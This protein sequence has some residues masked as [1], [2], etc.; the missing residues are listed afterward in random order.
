MSETDSLQSYLKTC[1][2]SNCG[3]TVN[4]KT[5]N[6]KGRDHRSI[7][8]WKKR[9]SQ[10][11]L[12]NLRRNN[13]LRVVLEQIN[14][15][16][17]AI[18]AYNVQYLGSSVLCAIIAAIA[19]VLDMSEENTYAIN[20]FYILPTIYLASLYN[21]VKYTGKQLEIGAYK[22]MLEQQTNLFLDEDVLCWESKIACGK[23]FV[24]LGGGVQIFFY[25]P[26]FVFLMHGFFKLSINGF[27]VFMMIFIIL[28]VLVLIIMAIDLC[29]VKEKTLEKMGYRLAN[30]T[31]EKIIEESNHV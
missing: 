10:S 1:C 23:K 21:L 19:T 22:M 5:Y 13:K 12:S 15:C 20:L 27:W 26:F 8:L 28:E 6:F 11:S 7:I 17:N 2:P 14:L 4:R 3:Q 31:L 30:G 16:S 18:T 24:I 25:I 9:K 29:K